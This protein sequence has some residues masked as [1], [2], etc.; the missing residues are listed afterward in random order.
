MG[1]ILGNPLTDDNVDDNS[2]IPY[3][4]RMGLI[5]DELYKATK[6]RCKKE[7]VTVDSRNIECAKNLEA[8]SE[9]TRMVNRAHILEHRCGLASPKPSNEENRRSIKENLENSIT[10][11]E[12]PKLGCREYAYLLSYY[13]QND[14]SVRDALHVE[15]GTIDTWER[16]TPDLPYTKEVQSSIHYHLSL[17]SRV[18]SALIY[19]GDHDLIVPY[20]GTE[21]WIKSLNF[22]II[23]DWRP[24]FVDSQ[25]GG[26]TAPEFMPKECLAMLTRWLSHNPL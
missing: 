12:L 5:L 22:S 26:H 18:Y 3:V 25:G 8:V 16:C 10:E 1:Y 17:S 11:R 6:R 24:W 20:L 4:H 21:A 14:D 2:K 9:C 7:Y 23:D 13:W 15:K 19:S